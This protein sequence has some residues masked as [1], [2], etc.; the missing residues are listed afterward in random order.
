MISQ[1]IFFTPGPSA[2]YFTVEEH[3]R[4]ALKEQIPSISHRS[5]QFSSLYQ[6]TEEILKSLVGLPDDYHL[7]FTASATE[8]WERM[9]QSCVLDK[10]LH[11]VN[12]AFSQRFYQIAGQLGLNP[13]QV[14][15][16]P[17]EVVVPAAVDH[18]GVELLAITHN[19]TSTGAQQPLE[20]IQIFRK[21]LPEALIA[22]D[23][24][25]S[26]PQV[27]L[28]YDL[29]D[30]VYFSVQK[31]MGLPAG[32]GVWLLN[33]RCVQRALEIQ[34]KTKVSYHGIASFW[35]KYQKYQTPATPNVL[36][37]FLLNRVLNDM[38]EKGIK[39]IRTEGQY[40]S[41]L[42]YQ[43]LESHPLLQPFVKEVAWRSQTVVVADAGSHADDLAQALL[44]KGLVV[45]RGYGPYKDAHIR[46][47]NF[48]THSKE[49]VEMLVDRMMEI[50]G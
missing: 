35:E 32:L 50:T 39:R 48:P 28:P 41:A 43:T 16:E 12:G 46:I 22:V 33:D 6:Q 10:S 37:I 47:A 3:M 44:Q 45:G 4:S 27:A 36:A 5:K 30:A 8:V 38:L 7:F 13:Q 17:G 11:L 1:K 15:V 25:S 31:C 20:D 34:S 42:L 29:V 18:Q 21:Q 14:R 23:A 19:E 2:L 9:L 49:T 40:K 24:V 26:F